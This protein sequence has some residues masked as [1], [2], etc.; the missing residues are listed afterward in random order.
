MAAARFAKRISI[1]A[2]IISVAVAAGVTFA[3]AATDSITGQP[4]AVGAAQSAQHKLDPLQQA[5]Y[6]CMAD[7]GS[8]GA[9]T[10]THDGEVTLVI[11]GAGVA[12]NE[13]VD[14]Q[15]EVD[16][17]FCILDKIGAPASLPARIG[18]TRALDGMQEASWGNYAVSWTYHPDDGLNIII[19]EN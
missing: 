10:E 13:Y 14:A 15:A 8:I 5:R 1:L 12:E 19:A 11:D 18:D 2:G 17:V 16:A 4:V 3:F 6:D 7:N 9:L